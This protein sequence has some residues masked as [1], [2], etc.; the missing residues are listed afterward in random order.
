VA[1]SIIFGEDGEVLH[2]AQAGKLVRQVAIS[3]TGER[4]VVGSEDGYIYGFQLPPPLTVAS[5]SV[6]QAELQPAGT[7][8]NIHINTTPPAW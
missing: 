5:P 8:Y 4:I 7:V 6:L 1:E 2:K 3:A